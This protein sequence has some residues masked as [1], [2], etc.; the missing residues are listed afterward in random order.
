MSD[1]RNFRVQTYMVQTTDSNGAVSIA[2]VPI[3]SGTPADGQIMAY[4]ETDR[5]WKYATLS[6]TSASFSASSSTNLNSPAVGSEIPLETDGV[7]Q[8][9]DVVRLSPTSF[10][11]RPGTYRLQFSLRLATFAGAGPT[12][13]ITY[14]F[15]D[16]TAAAGFGPVG[17]ASGFAGGTTAVCGVSIHTI[18]RF[19]VQ[20]IVSVK[21]L[22]V[23]GAVP[24]IEAPAVI[25]I[26][27]INLI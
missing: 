13:K 6:D 16:S 7:I 23:T 8:G 3:A 20:S 4:S 1:E 15:Y 2:G 27:K 11:V 24:S 19:Q 26:D 5:Q 18:A 12:Q 9:T 10:S 17:E 21:L 22:T 25:G 14:Q